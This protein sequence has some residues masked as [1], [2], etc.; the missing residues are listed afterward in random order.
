MFYAK[1]IAIL[2][3]CVGLLATYAKESEFKIERIKT[4]SNQ[5]KL[6]KAQELYNQEEISYENKQAGVTLAGTLT[7]PKLKAPFS[8]I[9]LISGKGPNDRDYTMLG[10]KLF[11]VLADYLT[12]QGFAVL[13]IDKRGVS[14]STGTFS[15]DLTSQDFAND[16][17]AGIEYLKNRKDIKQIGLIGHSEGGLI[18]SIVASKSKDVNSVVL[19]AG[20]AATSIDSIIEQVAMQ[21]KAD[22]ATE[23]TINLD[24]TARRKLLEIIKQ[25]ANYS[26]AEQELSKVIEQYLSSMPEAQKNESEKLLFAINSKNAQSVIAMFNSPWYRY[27]LN[28]DLATVLEQI[29]VPVLAINGN[30]DFITASK[31]NLPIIEQALK[32]AGNQNCKT[33]E[34]P[35]LNHWLQTCKTGSIS[36]YGATEETISPIALKTIS[37]WLQSKMTNK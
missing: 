11:L 35:K 13:R 26:K 14:K 15:V 10:H 1:C 3:F 16:I 8:A 19:M 20:V 12:R 2:F 17:L 33:I 29:K 37:D 25:E 7:L 5:Y 27:F 24:S 9:F 30:L 18:A 28:F 21:L 23:S 34:L 6:N 36:E 22:G 31:I 4:M 32:K